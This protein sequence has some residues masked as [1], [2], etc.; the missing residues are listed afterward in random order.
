MKTILLFYQL[1][2]LILSL[3]LLWIFKPKKKVIYKGKSVNISKRIMGGISLGEIIIINREDE[4]TIKHEYG[5]S[6]QSEYLGWLYLIIVGLP[7]ITKN[8]ISRI[9]KTYALN[10]YKRFPEK[11]AD[12]LGGVI[13]K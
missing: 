1:P 13:R 6:K 3:F 8:I 4:K 10:Y 5:H 9:N 11:W 7:S 12:R 2:Q